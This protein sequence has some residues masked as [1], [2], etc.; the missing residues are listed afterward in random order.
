MMSP[1][2][3]HAY[4][5]LERA[6]ADAAK[7]SQTFVSGFAASEAGPAA[8]TPGLRS[9]QTVRAATDLIRAKTAAKANAKVLRAGDQM[10][11]SLLDILA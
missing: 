2:S 4:Q 3:M 11:G 10:M 9:D 8:R 1:A 6:F 7:A 5:G